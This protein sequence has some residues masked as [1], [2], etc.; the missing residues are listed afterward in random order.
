M[1]AATLFAAAPGPQIEELDEV[2][3]TAKVIVPVDRF[4]DDPKYDSVAISP[5]GSKIAMSWLDDQYRRGVSILDFPSLKPLHGFALPGQL[6]VV[7][8]DWANDQ[9][10][11][12]NGLWPVK[13]F[14]RLRDPLGVLLTMDADGGRQE[15]TNREGVM[16]SDPLA[17]RRRADESSLAATPEGI[18][19]AGKMPG[20][21]TQGPVRLVRAR[22]GDADTALIQTTRANSRSG[23][24]EGYGAF[25]LNVRDNKL[26]RIA[27]LPVAG[28]E[29]VTGPDQRVALVSGIN[30][31][32][33]PVVYYLP[34][35]VRA[36]GTGWKLV[37]SSASG[38]RGLRPVAW[39]GK[40]EEYY[41]LDGRNLPTRGVVVWNAAT[42]TQ[43]LVF[44]NPVADMEHVALDPAGKAWM[45]R[46]NDHYPVYWYPDPNHPLARLHRVVRQK[47]K[48]DLIEVVSATDDLS[49]AV[50]K[51][52]AARRPPV[53]LLLYV[54]NGSAVNAGLFTYPHLR[55]TRLSRVEPIEF[56]A[57]DGMKIRGYLTTPEDGNGKPRIG[58]PLVVIAHDGPAGD[59][60]VDSGFDN[61]RQL[62][63]S[64][65]YAVLQVNRRG[66]PGLGAAFERAGDGKWGTAIQSD[67]IDGARWAIRDGVADAERICFYGTGY[68]AYSGMVAAAAEP[69]LFNCVVGVEGVYD[70]PQHLG[71]GEKPVPAAL[72]QVLG[73]DMAEMKAR[74]PLYLVDRIKAQV[75][76]VPQQNAEYFSPEQSIRMRNALKEAG[77]TAQYQIIGQE[78]DGLHSRE[79]RANGYDLIFRF[80]RKQI[81]GD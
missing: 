31:R 19:D 3:V 51:V 39:T 41:A 23:S 60:A 21:N 74:S 20:G 5:D 15:Y 73:T 65:G 8:V 30:H 10:L 9:R 45:F 47:A 61:E 63:A 32:N 33:E 38:Q 79:T 49:V 35:E 77:N 66:L 29:V 40:G 72:A 13:S 67:Y 59:P 6:N 46:G 78:Y 50:V 28:G 14:R 81:G 75:L 18:P 27:S 54:S 17:A 7:E 76:L 12:L 48:E 56:T 70:L 64:R 11:M 58:L 1:A 43:Q 37:A 68:G 52:S 22:F 62:F 25:Q 55:G 80:L 26:T 34:P 36:G 44:R 69:G 2:L 53:Y 71:N 16:Q 42:N 24:G 57:R 4:I